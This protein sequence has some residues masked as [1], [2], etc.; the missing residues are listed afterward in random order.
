VYENLA[1]VQAVLGGRPSIFGACVD[2]D[3][4]PRVSETPAEVLPA[5]GERIHC[6]HITDF[7]DGEEYL[8][9]DGSLDLAEVLD[10]PGIHTGIDAP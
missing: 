3:H 9:G 8:P 10:L 5:L 1:E 4:Y 2:T 6:V 7:E